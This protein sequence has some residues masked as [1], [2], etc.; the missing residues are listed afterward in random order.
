MSEERM[1]PRPPILPMPGQ[2][3]TKTDI[4]TRE[5]WIDGPP[6]TA[7]PAIGPFV[8][9]F[10]A[11]GWVRELTAAAPRTA[12]A[13][14]TDAPAMLDEL[15]ADAALVMDLMN[16]FMARDRECPCCE[17]RGGAREDGTPVT[18]A[19]FCRL[20]VRLHALTALT[21]KHGGG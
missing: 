15:R 3:V 7:G 21:K 2:V 12:A 5:I 9:A 10:D 18:H 6:M 8:V 1:S 19:P 20:R 14:I 11:T 4:N 17:E 13:L 16:S